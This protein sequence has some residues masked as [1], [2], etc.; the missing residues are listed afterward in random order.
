MSFI[1]FL[2]ILAALIFVH[3]LGH[4]LIAKL[5]KIRVD[6]FALGF[7]PTL[8]KKKY[9]ETVYKLNIIP[10]GGYVSIFGENPDDES[11]KGPDAHRSMVNMNRAKQAG[12]L[13]AGVTFNI[14]FAWILISITLVLG[15]SPTASFSSQTNAQTEGKVIVTSVIEKSPASSAG[16]MVGDLIVKANDSDQEI[17]GSTLTVTSIQALIAEK[18]LDLITFEV[19]RGNET[20]DIKVV[21]LMG[22]LAD[23]AEKPAIGISMDSGELVKVPWYTAPYNGLITTYHA[24]V[25]TASGLGQFFLASVQGTADFKQVSGPIGIVGMVGNASASGLAYVLFFTAII[26]INLAVINILP[27]PALDGGRL[28]FVAIESVIRKNISPRIMN[29][30]N[31]LGFALLILLML[32]VTYH[33]I[34]KMFVK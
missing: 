4:F 29:T 7:P 34:A 22:I 28:L 8:F 32:V 10:F 20:K 31:A 15:I 16:F 6:E 23:L 21:P 17:S 13:L 11:M 30:F 1:L 19:I 18:D 24:T 12:V 9:G 14:I 5:F 25:M 27:F 2:I 33:D 26:S 3:E